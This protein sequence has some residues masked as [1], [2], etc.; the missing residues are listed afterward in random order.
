[1]ADEKELR[2]LCERIA[3]LGGRDQTRLLE[4]VLAENR[5][6]YEAAIARMLAAEAEVREL[7]RKQREVDSLPLQSG[8]KREA[9]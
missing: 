6:R 8:A 5:R 7:E 3:S 1:M 4:M 2:E 9:G